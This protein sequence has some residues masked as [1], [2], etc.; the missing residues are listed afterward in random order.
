MSGK[1][2]KSRSEQ[3]KFAIKALIEQ[4]VSMLK[5]QDFDSSFFYGKNKYVTYF[6]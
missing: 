3:G 6:L 5:R 4:T 1:G 2:E